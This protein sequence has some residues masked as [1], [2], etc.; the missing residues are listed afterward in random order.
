MTRN[1]QKEISEEE[2]RG[3]YAANIA[4]FTPAARLQIERLFIRRSNDAPEDIARLDKVREALRKGQDFNETATQL[5]DA[6]LP[7]LPR[8]LLPPK[9]MYDYLGPRLTEAASRL[10]SPSISDAIADGEGWHFLRIVR[11]EPGTPPAFDDIRAQILT[12]MQR[13]SD[14]AALVDYLAWLKERAAI[15]LADDA[16]Q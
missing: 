1:A 6:V 9:K 4:R 13:E 3:F 16:P 8:S 10:P 15:L 7:P 2:L 5:G 11:S 12:A 14:D